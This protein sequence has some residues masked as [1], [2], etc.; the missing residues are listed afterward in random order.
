MDTN[1][2]RHTISNRSIQLLELERQYIVGGFE[3]VPL[4]FERGK[5]SRLWDVDGKEYIDF[6]SMFSATNHG[7]CHPH[8]AKKVTEQME[9]L[10]VANLA[11]HNASYGPFAE[12]MCKRFGYDKM[13]AMTSGTEAADTAC[14]LARKWGIQIKGIAAEN[15]LILGVGQ[16]Y[17][18]LG[19]GVWGLMDGTNKRTE[20]GLDSQVYMNVNPST[21]ESLHYLDLD[22]MRRCFNSHHG[23]IAAVIMECFH[24]V[25][26][27]VEEEKAYARG[28]YDLCREYGVLFI[29]DEVRQGAGKTG[30]FLSYQHLG[31][32]CKPDIVT[33]GKSISGG[34][35]PAS[36]ILGTDTVMTLV[37]SYEMASTFAF[38]PLAIA[39]AT[40]AVE[41]IDSDNLISRGIKLGERWKAIVS[42]W[43][44]PKVSYVASLGAESNLF[45]HCD[46]GNRLAALCMHKGLFVYPRADGLRISFALNMAMEDLER[47]AEIIR[48]SLDELDLPGEV[49]GEDFY[50]NLRPATGK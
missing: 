39:A 25:A 12:M 41:V 20:Y 49:V 19:S 27:S 32:D 7:H 36:F 30:K 43:N 48:E 34:F 44:H 47:G 23:R 3:P 4:M 38:T 31:N 18:G 46:S 15:L 35:Y 17:H 37:K 8:I 11:S 26:R 33:M 21:G 22:A 1:A 29:A 45:L 24:G 40:A 14:K 28:V 5:G 13:I 42:G 6:I 50:A 10:W 2:P 9:K 16:S